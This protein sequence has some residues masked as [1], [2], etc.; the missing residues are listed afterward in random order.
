R[1]QLPAIVS[2]I[3]AASAVKSLHTTM[4]NAQQPSPPPPYPP[5]A[6]YPQDEDELSLVDLWN[7]VWKRKWLWLTL[8]PLAGV[9]GIIYALAQPEIFRAEVTLA[10]NVEEKGG[11]GLAALAGQFG[12]LASMAGLNVGGG[13]DTQTALATLKSRKF[14]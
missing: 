2:A 14:L 7:I 6:Y 12:G 5:Y 4:S 3:S 8:G 11:G 13:G 10:P 1:P 9:I